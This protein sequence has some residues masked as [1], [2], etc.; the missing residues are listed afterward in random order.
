MIELVIYMALGIVAILTIILGHLH[1][2]YE[3]EKLDVG[4]D[5]CKPVG[6]HLFG[7]DIRKLDF[8]CSY[9]ISNVVVL[10]VDV[11]RSRMEDWIVSQSYGPLVVAFQ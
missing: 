11:L 4:E 9:L 2:L 6:N 7:R 8:L 1:L 10:D 3:S 5:F